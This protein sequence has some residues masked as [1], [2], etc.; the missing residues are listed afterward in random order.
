MT[1]LKAT[2]KTELQKFL[3]DQYAGFTAYPVSAAEH[4]T[5]MD[6]AIVTYLTPITV[7][8]PVTVTPNNTQIDIS[9]SGADYADE[10]ILAVGAPSLQY[11]T[12]TSDAYEAMLIKAVLVPSGDYLGG[13]V[14]PITAITTLVAGQKATVKSAI[15]AIAGTFN[16]GE[17]FCEALADAIH[18]NASDLP[19]IGSTIE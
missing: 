7:V 15:T 6:A 17:A 14:N 1:I 2:L 9:N 10:L 12:E 19:H 11:D 13:A 4:K 3:D 16:T 18:T 5:K 8:D